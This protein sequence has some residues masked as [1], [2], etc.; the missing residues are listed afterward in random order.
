MVRGGVLWLLLVLI[1]SFLI[2]L[3]FS[4]GIGL[5]LDFFLKRGHNKST[6][7]T[8][9][10]VIKEDEIFYIYEYFDSNK[11]KHYFQDN[12]AVTQ[13]YGKKEVGDTIKIYYCH[14]NPSSF[15]LKRSKS[16]LIHASLFLLGSFI[17]ILIFLQFAA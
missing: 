17:G 5:I 3:F 13:A 15:W 10:S 14:S 12:L 16:Q 2:L 4:V 7:A 6:Y 8:K 9:T 1:I 11:Q